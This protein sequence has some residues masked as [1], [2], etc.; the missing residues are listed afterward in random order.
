MFRRRFSLVYEMMDGV[1]A[2]EPETVSHPPGENKVIASGCC[3]L[4]IPQEITI[5]PSILE[6]LNR[7]IYRHSDMCQS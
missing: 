3:I 1:G 4:R 7:S 5:F 2:D 6:G